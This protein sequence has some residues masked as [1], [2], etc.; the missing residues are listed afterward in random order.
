MLNDLINV[1]TKN[2]GGFT[3]SILNVTL[4]GLYCCI[5]YISKSMSQ[6]ATL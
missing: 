1:I 2:V 4:E 5:S 6:M 3:F